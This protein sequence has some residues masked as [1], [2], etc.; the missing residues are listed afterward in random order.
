M[1]QA[2]GMGMRQG[3][4]AYSSTNYREQQNGICHNYSLVKILESGIYLC[5]RGAMSSDSLKARDLVD[6]AIKSEKET[7]DRPKEKQR[8]RGRYD[9]GWNRCVLGDPVVIYKCSD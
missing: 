2:T 5:F 7:R 4:W 9:R 6:R 1:G 3:Q 8:K